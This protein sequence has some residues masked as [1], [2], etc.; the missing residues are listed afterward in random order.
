MV[1]KD[2][3]GNGKAEYD[4]SSKIIREPGVGSRRIVIE[5]TFEGGSLAEVQL[6]AEV[7]QATMIIPSASCPW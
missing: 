4:S 3:V 7:W 2:C 5:R 6:L 1:K